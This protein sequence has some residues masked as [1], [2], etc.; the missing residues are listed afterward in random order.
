MYFYPSLEE[1]LVVTGCALLFIGI[2]QLRNVPSA[3]SR[4]DRLTSFASGAFAL[5]LGAIVLM[6]GLALA[7]LLHVSGDP[8]PYGY[9][10]DFGFPVLAGLFAFAGFYAY[11]GYSRINGFEDESVGVLRSIG[12]VTAI[13]CSLG[14]I[15]WLVMTFLSG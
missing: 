13:V 3:Y 1:L 4:E 7:N 10:A 5:V 11:F 14:L 2:G 9:V 8:T 15:V 12:V 6:A